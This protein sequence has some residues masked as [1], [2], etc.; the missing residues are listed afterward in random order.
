MWS[1]KNRRA[2]QVDEMMGVF[3]EG[4]GVDVRDIYGRWREPM[5]K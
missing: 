2:F 1:E 4:T 3:A 5:T